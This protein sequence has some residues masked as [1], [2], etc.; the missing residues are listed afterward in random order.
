[1]DEQPREK[2]LDIHF[3][4]TEWQGDNNLV[5]IIEVRTYG[6]KRHRIFRLL[7]TIRDYISKTQEYCPSV[8]I[9]EQTASQYWPSKNTEFVERQMIQ[10][11]LFYQMVALLFEPTKT[12]DF[13]NLRSTGAT[14]TRP[15]LLYLPNGKRFKKDITADKTCK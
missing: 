4:T 7:N 3:V 8:P 12:M 6:E 2:V 5:Y 1:L 15:F 9:P 13:L 11:E 10:L 14:E